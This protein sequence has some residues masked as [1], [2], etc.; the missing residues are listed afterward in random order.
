M[1]FNT[2]TIVVEMK[3]ETPAY[4]GEFPGSAI[5]GA[6]MQSIIYRHCESLRYGQCDT[7]NFSDCIMKQCFKAKVPSVGHLETNPI[8]INTDFVKGREYA[9]TLNFSIVLCGDNAIAQK[10]ELMKILNTG[11][12][13]GSPKVEFKIASTTETNMLVNLDTLAQEYQ[14]YKNSTIRIHLKTPFVSKNKVAL[15]DKPQKFI[16]AL[17]TRVTSMVI[18]LGIDFH[19]PYEQ[20]IETMDNI[21]LTE[22][23][24]ER[25]DIQRKSTNHGKY[26]LVH[27]EIGD[28]ILQ[29][30]FSHI[31]PFLVIAS[32]L[33]IG[34]E[35]T[36]GFGEFSW[37]VLN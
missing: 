2:S 31:Y 15:V 33:S 4:I 7:C 34:K 16:R 23:N 10:G 27:G 12:F 30:D 35:C 20:V 13:I 28:F 1:K 29:G 22:S 8:I 32:Q 17:T 26:Q 18:S 6:L 21:S 14:E 24:I 19:V 37:E 36:M 11:M 3:S 5:R 25:V 9:D